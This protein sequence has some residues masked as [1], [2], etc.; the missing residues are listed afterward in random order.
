M[1]ISQRRRRRDLGVAAPGMRSR[2]EFGSSRRAV[3]DV[4]RR[5]AGGL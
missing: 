2:R 1:A 5:E 3:G 4:P